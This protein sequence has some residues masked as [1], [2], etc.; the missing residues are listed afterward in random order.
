MEDFPIQIPDRLPTRISPCPIAEAVA[1][2]RFTTSESWRNIPGIL[3]RILRE[4]FPHEKELPLNSVPDEIRRVDPQ[5]NHK[6]HIQYVGNNFIVQL[7]PQIASITT[8][9]PYPGWSAYR[10]QIDWLLER[11]QEANI[12]DEGER[13]GLRYIDFFEGNLF[14]HLN[15]TFRFGDSSLTGPEFSVTKV[16]RRAPFQARLVL[17][18]SVTRLVDNSHKKGGVLD[19]DVAVTAQDFE[20]FENGLAKL[21][22]AHNLNKQVFFGILSESFLD[23]LN[24]EYP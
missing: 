7:G 4:R 11:L 15:G 6:P 23:S 5:I 22:E 16:L 17:N 24:P 19:L 18:N 21:D 10:D 1:E 14:D 3:A 13:I 12:V 9:G 8:K 2:F 20:L